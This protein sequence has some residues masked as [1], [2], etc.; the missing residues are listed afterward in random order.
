MVL[1]MNKM[2]KKFLLLFTA[3]LLIST[4]LFAS[5]DKNGCDIPKNFVKHVNIK[6][7]T[8]AS[9]SWKNA[10][11]PDSDEYTTTLKLIYKSGDMAVIEHKFCSMYN[12]ELTY[13]VADNNFKATHENI[14]KLINKISQQ[15]VA[16]KTSFK[17]PLDEAIK[18]KL[19][20]SK[21]SKSKP[22]DLDLSV[23]DTGNKNIEQSIIYTIIKNNSSKYRSKIGYYIGIGGE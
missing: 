23:P 3:A 10:V 22:F 7:T 6:D 15:S 19:V 5:K 4:S 1:K 13:F 9:Q 18:I 8:I 21:L 14:G 20:Q 12:Y 2:F 17:T 11:D 16:I